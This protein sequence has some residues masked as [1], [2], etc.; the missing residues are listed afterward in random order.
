LQSTLEKATS[1]IA[2]LNQTLSD[3]NSA[4]GAR[5]AQIAHP[6]SIPAVAKALEHHHD[7]LAD[8]KQDRQQIIETLHSAV[9]EMQKDV[10]RGQEA[11]AQ[12]EK[13]SK[14]KVWTIVPF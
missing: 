14:Q 4:L 13:I 9:Q 7:R 5:E 8:L 3:T 12:I 2:H 11:V 10:E 1:D 6:F